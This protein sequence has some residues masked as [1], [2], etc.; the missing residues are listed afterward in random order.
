MSALHTLPLADMLARFRAK[1]L[2]PSAYLAH[3]L[4]R[5]A[6]HDPDLNSIVKLDGE[7]ARTAALASDAAYASGQPRALDGIPVAIKD[8]IDVVGLPTTCHSRIR[9]DH[10]ATRDAA[11]VAALRRAGAIILAKTATHE[12]AIGGPAF[13]L[14]FPPAR[15]PWNRD[16]HPGG[17]SSGSAAGVAAGLFPAAIGTD[18]GGSV[19]HPASACG[20]VGL[21]PTYD[22]IS[23]DGVF[24]LAFSLDHV[25]SLTRSVADAALLCDVMAQ[26][27]TT[28][29]RDIGRDIRGLRV[30]YVRH[31][32]ESDM[33]AT[34]DV[35]AAL[36]AAA[37]R[38]GAAGATVVDVALP[39]LRSFAACNRIILQAEAIAVHGRWLRERPEDYCALSRRGILPGAFLSAEDLVQAQRR[40]RQLI[41]H[42][43]AALQDVDVLLT[44][45]SMEVACRIDDAAEI[46]R[47]YGRQARTPF[48]VTGHPAITLPSG[49]SAAGLPLSLQIAGRAND[50][51]TICRVA[52]AIELPRLSPPGV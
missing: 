21:K 5:I 28:A 14:P 38:F 30:G 41:A 22:A 26:G 27:R 1:D 12:F 4:A 48:N 42:V 43:E 46:A 36:D 20:I 35:A 24:P 39:D 50:E 40:R 7:A 11:A 34:P 25:G 49:L 47:T 32:H 31:F 33:V 51:A 18:T 23:R 8:V 19:R 29:A 6:A 45:S 37:A 2:L 52:A 16:H 3:H 17:S 15:N 44:A 10:V 13:D 9:L